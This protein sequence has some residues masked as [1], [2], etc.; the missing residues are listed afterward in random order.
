MAGRAGDDVG[1]TR[2]PADAEL[3]LR[4]EA[5]RVLAAAREGRIHAHARDE[6][7]SLTYV[8]DA[9]VAVG[10]LDQAAAHQVVA[11]LEDAL[12]LRGVLPADAFHPRDVAASASDD[13]PPAVSVDDWVRQEVDRLSDLVRRST[14]AWREA[15]MTKAEIEVTAAAA[16]FGRP[17]I[18]HAFAVATGGAAVVDRALGADARTWSH[19]AAV[20]VSEPSTW[21]AALAPASVTIGCSGARHR[22]D[23]DHGHLVLHD[24]G[25]VDAALAF[26]ALGGESSPC[27]RLARAWTDR[28]QDPVVLLLGP[29][30]QGDAIGVDAATV[31]RHH[32]TTARRKQLLRLFQQPGRLQHRLLV[33]VVVALA[34]DASPASDPA[35]H[36]ALAGR[37]AAP[38]R[39]A[40]RRVVGA[41]PVD[42][43]VRIAPPGTAAID[44]RFDHAAERAEVRALLPWSWLGHV[45][46]HGLTEVDKAF[47]VDAGTAGA[48]FGT[49]VEVDVLRLRDDGV[50][51]ERRTVRRGIGTIP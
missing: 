1:L 4:L 7:Q 48:A 9:F 35:L 26:V 44:V 29:R 10:W 25:D 13:P 18:R 32:G 36:A 14:P 50:E 31:A 22:V 3:Y 51:V 43:D 39:R 42:V 2:S 12:A 11:D 34:S 15:A 49:D 41:V 33:D 20:S 45:W 16:A 24:H 40:V 38:L 27:V 37:A 28:R 46:I 8:A 17:E 47:V 23:W 21:T 19:R 6:R 30:E 5:E